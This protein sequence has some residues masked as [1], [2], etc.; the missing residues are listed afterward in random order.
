VVCQL[1]LALKRRLPLILNLQ[2]LEVPQMIQSEDT[3]QE[4]TMKTKLLIGIII[5]ATLT[6]SFSSSKMAKKERTPDNIISKST[7]KEPLGGFVLE[8]RMN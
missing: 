1:L 3:K 8:D 7:P 5:S 4:P 2:L 6:L